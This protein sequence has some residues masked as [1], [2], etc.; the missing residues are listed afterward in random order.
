LAL[1]MGLLSRVPAWVMAAVGVA[2]FFAFLAMPHLAKIS[3]WTMALYSIC[4]VLCGAV[5]WLGVNTRYGTLLLS[6][7]KSV[8]D[9]ILACARYCY[10]LRAR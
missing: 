8:S 5:L 7:R 3:L 4:G 2:T 1:G 10:S 9:S 6:R